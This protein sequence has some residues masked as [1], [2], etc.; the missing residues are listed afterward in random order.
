MDDG[1]AAGLREE[2]LQ[3]LLDRIRIQRLLVGLI[4]PSGKEHAPKPAAV[5]AGDLEQRTPLVGIGKIITRA[6]RVFGIE[7]ERRGQ[8]QETLGMGVAF[9]RYAERLAH[10]GT[11]AI[12]ADQILSTYLARARGVCGNGVDAVVEL[13]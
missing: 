13:L 7:R 1:I 2:F 3:P 8:H 9:E 5:V 11:S 6:L 12:G 4:Q 10:G